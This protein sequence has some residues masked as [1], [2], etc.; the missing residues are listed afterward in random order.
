LR[1]GHFGELLRQPR[2]ANVPIAKLALACGFAD[3]A[4]ATR[5]FKAAFGATPR[6]YRAGR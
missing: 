1:V 3:A 5:T 2:C 6:E 4:H